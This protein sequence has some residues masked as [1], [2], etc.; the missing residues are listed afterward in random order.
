MI[1][2]SRNAK[3]A[4]LLACI[5]GNGHCLRPLLVLQR[6]NMECDLLKFIFSLAYI[7]DLVI[8]ERST[9]GFMNTDMFLLWTEHSFLPE[10]RDR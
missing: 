4:R 2:V 5:C 10:V 8:Y 6:E 3:H 7:L 9:T 1:L